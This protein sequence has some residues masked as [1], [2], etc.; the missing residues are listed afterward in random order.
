[1]NGKVLHSLVFKKEKGYFLLIKMLFY[2]N[3]DFKHFRFCDKY[4]FHKNVLML[5]KQ[6]NAKLNCVQRA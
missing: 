1:M 2:L 4:Y 5:I 6:I 3:Y